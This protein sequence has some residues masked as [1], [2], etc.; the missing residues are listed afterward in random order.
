M[1]IKVIGADTETI[2][3]APDTYQLY[4]GE[5]DYEIHRF[6][7]GI[8]PLKQMLVA[9]K[10]KCEAGEQVA[11]F[12]HN[13]QFDFAVLM[14]GKHELL[15]NDS[16]EFKIPDIG[17][18]GW[19]LYGKVNTVNGRFPDGTNIVFID[20]FQYFQT[21]LAKL[22]ETFCP[23]LPK[24]QKPRGLGRIRYSLNDSRFT[25]YAMR[26]S[27]I[28]FFVGEELIRYHKTFDVSLSFSGP[29][30]A[31]RVFRR[32]YIPED[33]KIPFPPQWIAN[34]AKLSFHGGR[35]ALW[36]EPGI[37]DNVKEL[38]ITSAYPFAMTQIPN[39]LSAQYIRARVHDLPGWLNL[40]G[41]G[42]YKIILYRQSEKFPNIYDHS[43]KFAEPM[44]EEYW[45]T[46][47]EL[48]E[49]TKTNASIEIK[50]GYTTYTEENFNPL[51]EYVNKIFQKKEQAKNN[52]SLYYF[53]KVSLLNA[54]YGKFIEA[55]PS[56][57]E[58][59]RYDEKGYADITKIFTAGRLYNPFIASLITGHTR[60]YLKRLEHKYS[61]LHSSTDSILTQQNLEHI[62]LPSGLG[63]LEIKY[64]GTALLIR[65]KL[66]ILFDSKGKIVKS[67]LHGFQ[68]TEQQLLRCIRNK[69]PVYVMEHMTKVRE[70]LRQQKRA[71]VMEKQ[72][73]E[74]NIP[75]EVIDK[76]SQQMK[77]RGL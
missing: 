18:E 33:K 13:L 43:F 26:D 2:N 39:V 67:A 64:E 11:V 60:A 10:K 42:I 29:Q 65:S 25:R 59:I 71:L 76:L 77:E 20:T 45:V 6:K 37:Y 30:F 50:L 57:M 28:T 72:E 66:Y 58:D 40:N 7:R 32:H 47:Y 63:G 46:G 3:G 49:A 15:V 22:A 12:I 36:V 24:L 55:R 68:G 19:F 27:E 16:V 74:L 38:D 21:S 70:S 34:A 4:Y 53:Y 44:V 62:K 51:A 75:M 23:H 14:Y 56:Q 17:F 5:K 41:G 35:N 31:S 48:L 69:K 1:K 54:L 8:L 73:R 52:P 9:I 61:A